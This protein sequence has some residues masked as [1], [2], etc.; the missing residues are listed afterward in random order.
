M[1]MSV[2]GILSGTWAR[3]DPIR[4]EHVPEVHQTADQ[5][6]N[7]R[8][9]KIAFLSTKLSINIT[10]FQLWL[11]R[12]SNMSNNAMFVCLFVCSLFLL[13]CLPSIPKSACVWFLFYHNLLSLL[14]AGKGK[15]KG[16][17]G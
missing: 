11:K 14:L 17:G 16:V 9:D 10:C 12:F 2:T 8:S 15:G 5:I 1:R 3:C 7:S 4:N 13:F 6:P